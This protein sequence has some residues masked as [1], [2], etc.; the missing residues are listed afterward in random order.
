MTPGSFAIGWRQVASAFVML[1]C[2]ATITTS[3]SVIAV[4]LAAEFKPSRTILLLAMTVVSGVSALLAPF[5]GTLMDKTSLRRLMML[6]ATL[7]AGGYIA[8]SFVQTFTQVLVVYGA[9]IAP[10]NVLLGPVAVTVLLSRWFSARRGRALG[11]AIAGIA[12]GSIIFPPIVQAFL[13]N[14]PWREAVRLFGLVIFA[15]GFVAA[16]LIINRPSDR[17]LQPDGAAFDPEATADQRSPFSVW[18]IVSDP[19]FW[20]IF[21]MVGVVTAGMKGMITNLALLGN[22][23]GFAPTAGALLI[24]VYGGCGLVAKLSFAA[25]ADRIN[26][27]YLAA[28]SLLGFASGMLMLSQVHFGYAFV[29]VGV[30]VTG[31]FGGLMVPL[32]SLLGARVFGRNAVGRAVGLLSMALLFLMLLTPPLFGKIFDLTGS[33]TA[34]FYLFSVLAVAATLIVPFVRFDAPSTVADPA[35]LPPSEAI[36]GTG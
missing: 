11:I 7:L 6:G 23:E 2:V 36:M 5:L 20:L 22:A 16:A 27:R 29:A 26:L 19:S 28:T 33:Y 21:M 17:A 18:K 15:C 30:G 4:P 24:S 32:E 12:M 3:Y 10:A 35:V 14:F 31:I 13:G 34:A 1:A 25:V 9:I 8:L